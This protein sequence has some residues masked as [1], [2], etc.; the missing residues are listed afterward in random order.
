MRTAGSAGSRRQ[1]AWSTGVMARSLLL[2]G[3]VEDARA[4]AERSIDIC[5]QERWNAFVPW[6]QAGHT[7]MSTPVNASS[8]ALRLVGSSTFCGAGWPIF[9]HSSMSRRQWEPR[10]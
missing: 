1:E 3:Q 2:A 9:R 5:D 8:K 10:Q 6:P 4:A 7:A